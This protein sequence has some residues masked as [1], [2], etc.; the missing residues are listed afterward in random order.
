[1]S[2]HAGGFGKTRNINVNTCVITDVRDA[3]TDELLAEHMWVPMIGENWAADFRVDDQEDHQDQSQDHGE[4]GRC[5][6]LRVQCRLRNGD[7]RFV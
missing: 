2:G 5:A 4:Q 7:R 1:V 6:R 3:A